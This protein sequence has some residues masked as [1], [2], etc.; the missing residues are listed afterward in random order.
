[1]SAPVSAPA[2]SRATQF[3]RRRRARR[4]DQAE[5]DVVGAQRAFLELPRGGAVA[6]AIIGGAQEAAALDDIAFVVDR[7]GGPFPDIADEVMHPMLVG[8]EAGD[9]GA[10]GEAVGG[11]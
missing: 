9:G 7:A 10:A 2:R 6:G 5:A 3:P 11:P 8:G 1:M 4:V